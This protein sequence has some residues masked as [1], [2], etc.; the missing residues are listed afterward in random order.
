MFAVNIAMQS[1]ALVMTLFLLLCSWF[2]VNHGNIRLKQMM[3]CMLW[4]NVILLICFMG[5]WFLEGNIKYDNLH[6]LLTCGKC[7][8]GYPFAIFYTIYI[9]SS[10]PEKDSISKVIF[11]VIV[12]VCGIAFILNVVSIWTNWYY[13]IQDGHYER[14]RFFLMN[15]LTGVSVLILDSFLIYVNRK[16]LYEQYVFFMLS[17]SVLPVIAAVVQIPVPK[18]DT[19][20]IA[21]SFSLLIIY[22]SVQVDRGRRLALQE[23]TMT[24]LRVAVMMSQIQPHFLYNAL[25]VIQDLCHD[26]APEAESATIEFSEFL[27]S[28][29]DSL[30]TTE[31]IPFSKELSHTQN[32]LKLEKRRFGDR[33]EVEYDIQEKNF[34]IPSLTLEPIVENAVRYGVTK[35]ESGGKIKI[36]SFMEEDNYILLI[37]D[38][39]NG[40]EERKENGDGRSHIG[41]A[42]V[43]ERVEQMC[44]GNIII[45]STIGEGTK[46]RIKIPKAE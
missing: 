24:D 22:I 33:L 11:K 40:I 39:G 43:R 42:N 30:Q 21:T 44:H 38:N 8:V 13:V 41:I 35:R 32:Y 20:C 29:L 36:S 34:E 1:F 9:L 17:Y 25:A 31:R 3:D 6:Y 5:S 19:M 2:D 12:A 45:E 7:G 46:V 14:G 37:E 15:Q 10:L 28:N 23:K 4:T 26:K 16:K 27:R 18:V